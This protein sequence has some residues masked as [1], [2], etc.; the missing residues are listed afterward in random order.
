[1]SLE[2]DQFVV[3]VA[4]H[5]LRYTVLTEREVELVRAIAEATEKMLRREAEAEPDMGRK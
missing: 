3:S 4:K 2:T 1:M 5:M